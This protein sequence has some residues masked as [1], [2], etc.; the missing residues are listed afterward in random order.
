MSAFIIADISIKNE[1]A[2][3]EY[4]AAITPS[5]Q[6]YDGQYKIRGGAP[7]ALRG[8]WQSERIVM[9]EF[10]NR[11]RAKQWLNADSLAAIHQQREDNAHYCHM[12]LCDSV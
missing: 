12:I 9:M 1:A 11:E 6:A 7:E 5:V 2:Y 4:I 8:E 10:P 3:R